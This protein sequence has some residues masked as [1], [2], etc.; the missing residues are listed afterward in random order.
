ML[1]EGDENSN[2]FHRWTS[3]RRNRNFISTIEN[4]EGIILTEQNDTEKEI[5]SY[6]DKLYNTREE[7]CLTF[8]NLG[9]SPLTET[10]KVQI[11][12]SFTVE[13]IHKAVTDLG[14]LKSPGQ[15]RTTNEF[16]KKAWNIFRTDLLKVFQDF[17]YVSFQRKRAQR[18]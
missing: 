17:F 10:L 7:H 8:E 15:D 1:K 16:F 5:V 18:V 6:F 13:E 4:G 3:G 2:F 14:C 9:W 12:A 11:E